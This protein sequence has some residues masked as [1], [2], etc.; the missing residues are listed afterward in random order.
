MDRRSAGESVTLWP[1][2]D[3]RKFRRG[4]SRPTTEPEPS[5]LTENKWLTYLSPGEWLFKEM[6]RVGW[7][8]GQGLCRSN[9]ERH[10]TFTRPSNARLT[11]PEVLVEM[12]NRRIPMA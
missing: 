4:C 12:G 6:S 2:C 7:S 9:R 5:L 11:L 8:P 10:R 3:T 1:I